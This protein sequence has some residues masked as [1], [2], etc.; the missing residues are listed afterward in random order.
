MSASKEGAI[1]T[2]DTSCQ[3]RVLQVEDNPG[4][5][6]L[7]FEFLFREQVTDIHLSQANSLQSAFELLEREYFDV[8]LLDLSLPDAEKLEGL[9]SLLKV[10]PKVAVVIVSSSD[11][12]M[13]ALKALQSGAQDYIV[14]GRF[15]SYTLNKSIRYAVERKKI[16]EHLSYLA[17]NDPL[18]GLLNRASFMARVTESIDRS[19]RNG[20]KLAVF[21]IDMDDFKLVNDTFGHSAGDDLLVQVA[22][23][24]RQCLRAEDT[25]ARLSGDEFSILIELLDESESSDKITQKLLAAMERPFYLSKQQVFATVSIGVTV[26]LGNEVCTEEALKQADMAMYKAKETIGSSCQYF[27]K[28]LGESLQVQ[29]ILQESVHQAICNGEMEI[30]YQPQFDLEY[31]LIGVEALLR[32]R[33]PAVGLVLPNLFIPLLEDTGNIIQCGKW[34]LKEACQTIKPLLEQGVFSAGLQLSVNISA[35]QIKWPDFFDTVNEVLIETGFP[36]GQL[37]LEI[38]ESTLMQDTECNI[39]TLTKLRELG[40]TF[41]IDDFGTG[42]SSLSY[43]AKFPSSC[44][45]IDSSLVQCHRNDKKTNALVKSIIGLSENLDK[46]L[47]AVGVET[48]RQ[49]DF[50]VT[51]GCRKFQGFYFSK[52]LDKSSLI[53][54]AKSSKVT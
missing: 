5:A 45:K 15:D 48:K 13:I 39:K 4:D 42:Y 54:F 41:S 24:F 34:V 30:E 6:R 46:D 23:R 37:I 2:E 35:K 3:I 26:F 8:I 25:L 19:K 29:R 33:H 28:S 11:D 38:T 18:T 47:I 17:L 1:L 32:W 40:V 12:E 10:A 31:S 51:S 52:P 50:L 43:L 44:I 9:Y 49:F 53:E 7:I 36:P 27:D 16:E 20:E 14:K 21:F 22:G